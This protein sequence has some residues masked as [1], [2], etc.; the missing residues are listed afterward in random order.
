MELLADIKPQ[1]QQYTGRFTLHR[2]YIP[3]APQQTWFPNRFNHHIHTLQTNTRPTT[4]SMIITSANPFEAIE[5]SLQTLIF[6]QQQPLITWLVV[7]WNQATL[8]SVNPLIRPVF[9]TVAPPKSVHPR[10]NRHKFV[11]VTLHG[12]VWIPLL[13]YQSTGFKIITRSEF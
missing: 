11:T 5:A 13:G 12:S 4:T 8:A 6:P 1:I 10:W 2:C 3:E 9:L 7:L